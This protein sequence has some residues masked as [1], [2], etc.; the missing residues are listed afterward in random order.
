MSVAI[1]SRVLNA[2]PNVRVRE[3]TR[4]RIQETAASMGYAPHSVA[5]ALRGGRTGAIGLVMHGL[6]SPINVDV[7]AGAR[8]HCADA[9]YVTLLADAEEL[10]EDH[11][12]LSAFLARGRL[13]GVIL[14]GGYGQEDHL[15]D[16]ISSS[17]PAVLINSD[18]G[19]EVPTVRV[20]DAA[21]G[22][23]ATE[24][25]LQLGHREVTFIAGSEGS[26]TSERREAGY[27]SALAH[28][29]RA[30]AVDV[31]HAGWSAE[32]GVAA[33]RTLLARPHLPTAL[34]TANAVTA[35]GVLSG[36]RD[37]GITVP[38]DISVITIHDSWF[39][40]HL[41]VA[42]SAVRLPL[43]DLG[44]AAAKLLIATVDGR[45]PMNDIFITEPTPELILRHSTAPP[46]TS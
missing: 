27:R 3:A 2:D 31:L 40:L 43:H 35:A 1:A 44:A 24:H 28:P 45:G 16:A 38:H 5:R 42:L 41:T 21:A 26:Q 19:R 8:R 18:D 11:S 23:L 7:F 33:A 4:Q 30:D 9:G 6:D 46:P 14:H 20:D 25:L 17:V 13:D 37:A 12:R 10:A 15:I 34:V 36:L 22:A 32:S 39:L 29:D